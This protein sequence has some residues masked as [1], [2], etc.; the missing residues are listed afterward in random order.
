FE[1][2]DPAQFDAVV[3]IDAPVT[4]RRT[5]LRALR[6]LSNE[7]ADRMIAAQMPAERKRPQ[8]QY[9]VE[10]AGTLGDLEKDAK[11]ICAELRKPHAPPGT[12]QTRHARAGS[13]TCRPTPIRLRCGST[14]GRGGMNASP[15]VKRMAQGW[16][17]ERTCCRLS[18]H[19]QHSE[20]TPVHEGPRVGAGQR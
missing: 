4:L 9:V 6:G 15:S 2:L 18:S 16:R 10:N 12:R 13:I 14:C 17:P 19:V 1:V 3:L 5:R 8:S 7:E 20:G 11:R